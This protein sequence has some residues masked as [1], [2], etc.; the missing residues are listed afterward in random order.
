VLL[1][2][3]GAVAIDL[4]PAMKTLV[5]AQH[6]RVLQALLISIGVPALL[7]ISA[8]IVGNIIAVVE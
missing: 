6:E 7:F 3:A 4:V 2:L 8:V 1:T 5:F